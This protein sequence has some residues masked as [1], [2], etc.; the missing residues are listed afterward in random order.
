MKARQSRGRYGLGGKLQK[1]APPEQSIGVSA[2]S[3]CTAVPVPPMRM[4]KPAI[5]L[6]AAV[7]ANG[8]I[9]QAGRLPW[10]LRSDMARFRGATFGKPVVMGRKTYISIGKPLAGRTNIVVSR[11]P[12]FSAAGVLVAPSIET[13][14][15]IARGD[16][17]RRGTDE[18]A[19]IGGADIFRDT[20]PVAARLLITWVQLDPEG[21][22]RF[23]S[24]DKEAWEEISR[25]NHP[26]GE[27]DDA[28]FTV[29]L[30]A[31]RVSH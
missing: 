19:V 26:R 27:D 23:P 16:A 7:A 11:A 10:R 1:S 21:D 9:G 3:A 8:V 2:E 31:R 18:I 24:I 30:Y 22:T 17:L 28:Q 14:L 15:T 13:A 25:A 12:S 5:V 4:S 29:S 20:L 6:V